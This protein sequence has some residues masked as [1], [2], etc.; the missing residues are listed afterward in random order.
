MK[1]R[2]PGARRRSD[3]APAGAVGEVD[4]IPAVQGR[5]D[6]I[7]RE[8]REK[9]PF[10]GIW[11]TLADL[12]ALK[13]T[14]NA[15]AGDANAKE[16]GTS[17]DAIDE[18]MAEHVAGYKDYQGGFLDDAE[19]HLVASIDRLGWNVLARM[20]LGNLFFVKGEHAKAAAA[21]E[22]ALPHC[23]GAASSEVLT[24]LGMNAFKAGDVTA[25]EK[26]F[27]RAIELDPAN[28]YAFN[29]L[30]LVSEAQDDLDAAITW[31]IKAVEANPS[32]EELWYN[33]GN[34]LGKAG[35]KAERLFCF[36]RAEK[37]GFSELREL[38]ED[39]VAQG[40]EPADPRIKGK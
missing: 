30:G 19:A 40:I 26:H 38:V 39:L 28:A 31:Y 14:L 10:M 36:L 34:V 23:G 16:G 33:L 3:D 4:S 15:R 5:I 13:A 32:D 35:K 1:L 18:S 27:A 6:E 17:P 24:N 11:G 21:F 25:A 7:K 37:R 12:Y 9:T 22:A 2:M 29:N 20:T 8:L